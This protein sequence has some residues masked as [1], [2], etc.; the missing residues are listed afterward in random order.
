MS[1]VFISYKANDVAL[2]NN[3][4]D[5]AKELCHELE[6]AGISCWMA[7]RDIQPGARYAQAIMRAINN[8]RVML[9]V[10]SRY[11]NHSEHIA[12]EVDKAFGSKKDIIPFN[13]DST[14]PNE[15]LDYYLCRK[16]WIDAAGDYRSRIHELVSVL[17]HQLGRDA[18]D[19]DALKAF[20]VNGVSFNM[21]FVQ[22]GTFYM[23][24]DPFDQ[25]AQDN[26]KPAHEVTLADF[27]IGQTLVTQQLWT[28]VMGSNP[29]EFN[30]DLRRPV[31]NVSFD[32]CK[33]FIGRLN[34]LT[35]LQFRLPTEAEWEFAARGGVK[36]SGKVF[37]GGNHIEQVSWFD[38]NGQGC[39]HPVAQKRPNELNIFDMCGNVSE[40]CADFY[41]DSYYITSPGV[42]PAGPESGDARVM[43]GGSWTDDA[44]C[45]RVST[46]NWIV[47]LARLSNLGLRLAL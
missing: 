30:D 27:H 37:A 21:V 26:E 34:L 6:K 45:C 8:C 40:W 15:E 31:E 33:M 2:G 41:N 3:D 46:R 4:A 16:Q 17:R 12:N 1:E 18:A 35:G 11:A 5:I 32:D 38:E 43:R 29:S 25:L 28:A 10:F 22:G 23:G 36:S 14:K 19:S 42:N 24:A 13:L 44:R 9:L 47:D 39:T 20:T 7:P